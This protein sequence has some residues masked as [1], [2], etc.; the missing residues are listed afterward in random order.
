VQADSPTLPKQDH[1]MT[2]EASHPHFHRVERT[3]PM[4]GHTSAETNGLP[5]VQ[6]G[7]SR[8]GLTIYFES[9]GSKKAY[10]AIPVQRP[11]QGLRQTMSNDVDEGFDEG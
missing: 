5:S 3:D 4:T 11:E 1:D 2:Y 6:E 10:E 8:D 9:E 7:D